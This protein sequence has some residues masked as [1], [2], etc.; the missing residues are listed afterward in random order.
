MS[1]KVQC[2]CGQ[3]YAFEV[4]PVAGRMPTRVACPA[5]GADGTDAANASIAQTLATRAAIS[6]S[7][8]PMQRQ[9]KLHPALLVG[10]GGAG[11]VLLLLVLLVTA[12]VVRTY[13]FR[14]RDRQARQTAEQNSAAWPDASRSQAGPNSRPAPP[15]GAFS[16]RPPPSS[17]PASARDAAPVP[18]DVTS[19]DV[20]WGNRW[21]PATILR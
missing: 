16:G 1:V 11:V 14:N 2:S 18:A 9:R 20:F 21:W 4:E 6:A 8:Q 7:P 13:S 12:S 3:N 19:V 5:C 15:P 17:K 10:I